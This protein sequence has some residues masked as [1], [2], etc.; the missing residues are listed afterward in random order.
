MMQPV[1][2]VRHFVVVP[3]AGVGARLGAERPKQ[4]QALAGATVLEHAIAPFLAPPWVERIVVAVAPQDTIAAGLRGVDHPRVAVV[5]CGGATRRETVRNALRE[6]RDRFAAAADDWVFVHDAARPG[7]D[8]AT[9]ARL[10]A[11]LPD[12]R[13]GALLAL[14]VVDTVKRGAAGRSMTTVDRQGLWLAQTPQVF[15]HGMLLR[16]LERHHHVTDEA[17]A[18]EESGHSGRLVEGSR[19]NH[20]ITTAQ[21]LEW[22]RGLME[23]AR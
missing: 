20:K 23:C 13:V 19:R 17:S 10:V 7:L 21:D 16:A 2:A 18:I 1:P 9:L 5:P 14:P 11:A 15:R 8:D 12:E 6:L 3:A 4:Y 22:M